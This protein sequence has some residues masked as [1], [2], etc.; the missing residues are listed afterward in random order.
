MNG[1][2][3]LSQLRQFAENL[4]AKN[5]PLVIGGGYGLLLKASHIQR[6]GAGGAHSWKIRNWIGGSNRNKPMRGDF[7]IQGRERLSI[8]VLE[9]S[10]RID[11]KGRYP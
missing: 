9:G 5:I 2:P 3:L 7:G 1:D 8:M 4:A 6:M 10:C 11:L